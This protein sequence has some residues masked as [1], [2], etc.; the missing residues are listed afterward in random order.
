[1]GEFIA[2]NWDLTKPLWEMIIVENYHDDDGAECALI[3]RGY[4][5]AVEQIFRLIDLNTSKTDIILLR[6]DKA[7]YYVL[8]LIT[9]ALTSCFQVSL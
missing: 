7:S 1:M 2:Q 4:V 8:S 9:H 5:V 6:T 3:V